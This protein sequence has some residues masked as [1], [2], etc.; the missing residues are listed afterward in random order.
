MMK[1]LKYFFEDDEVVK[2]YF[3]KRSSWKKIFLKMMKLE[4]N[5]FSCRVKRDRL[6]NYKKIFLKMM[7]YKIFLEGSSCKKFLEGSSC[8]I[9][10]FLLPVGSA[11]GRDNQVRYR[12]EIEDDEVVKNFLE[13]VMMKL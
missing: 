6:R 9:F 3:L 2:K 10:L 7:S 8:K 13:M 11:R 4:K 1:L 12:S 5:F